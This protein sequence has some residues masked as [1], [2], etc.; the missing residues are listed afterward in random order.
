MFEKVLKPLFSPLYAK[1]KFPK[2]LPTPPALPSIFYEAAEAA[3]DSA[4]MFYTC[5]YNLDFVKQSGTNQCNCCLSGL[6]D[7]KKIR[8]S[9]II[10][11]LRPKLCS[12]MSHGLKTP[13]MVSPHPLGDDP[14]FDVCWDDLHEAQRVKQEAAAKAANKA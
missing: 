12:M 11:A 9:L 14:G 13:E 1:L 7:T 10:S 2:H 3:K 6:V 4:I 8:S 5:S